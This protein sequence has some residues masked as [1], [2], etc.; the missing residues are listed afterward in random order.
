M[1]V[2]IRREWVSCVPR[3]AVDFRV[4]SASSFCLLLS[5]FI[6]V[7]LLQPW[8]HDP[9][10]IPH[11]LRSPEPALLSLNRNLGCRFYSETIS[12]PGP[13]EKSQEPPASSLLKKEEAYSSVETPTACSVPG[14]QDC[15]RPSTAMCHFEVDNN[16]QSPSISVLDA[17]LCLVN[18]LSSL[19]LL[20]GS[21]CTSRVRVSSSVICTALV[22]SP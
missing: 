16:E 10:P 3:A 14:S 18:Q 20:C 5:L 4:K 22:C 9:P 12:Y 2:W 17:P 21:L 19:C 15:C 11:S 13:N 7:G 8:P 1:F 6:I